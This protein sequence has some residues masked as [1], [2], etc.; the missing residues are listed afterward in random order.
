MNNSTRDIHCFSGRDLEDYS[1]VSSA[2]QDT[3]SSTLEEA[4]SL[5]STLQGHELRLMLKALRVSG[6][7]KAYGRNKRLIIA[8]KLVQ[9]RISMFEL[10]NAIDRTPIRDILAQSTTVKLEGSRESQ[11]VIWYKGDVPVFERDGSIRI[12]HYYEFV[13]FTNT[14]T[15]GREPNF[16]ASE[17][18][19]LGHVMIDPRMLAEL[20]R[21]SGR[22]TKDEL[23]RELEDPWTLSFAPLYNDPEF[24]PT[25]TSNLAGGITL[26]EIRH[27]D[28]ST[29][30]RSRSAAV[31]KKKWG[32]VRS[33]YTV[34]LERYE[35]SGQN[36]YSTFSDFAQGKSYVMYFHC[37]LELTPS[38]QPMMMRTVP[39]EARREIGVSDFEERR[40]VKRAGG[41]DLRDKKKK[42]S[43]EINISGL[44]L[45]SD[46][47]GPV[48]RDAALR[49]EKA[50]ATKKSS[51]EASSVMTAMSKVRQQKMEATTDDE[52]ED[53]STLL[54][55]L[56]KILN[57]L[58]SK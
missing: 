24:K 54:E 55:S 21:V 45:L 22:R 50:E 49:S 26:E 51:E 39:D 8:T 16:E 19:K 20:G 12:G 5:L 48:S 7:S 3:P 15:A 34:I 23:D 27:I 33:L 53:L 29:L 43:M 25:R 40:S 41:D 35:Q 58:I 37:I 38:L 10:R 11:R 42:K 56:K 32:E 31:L 1:E 57:E 46:A 4:Q 30:I 52:R 17:F 13:D 18:A 14:T 36:D 28:P 9:R 44:E 47:L 6:A 2:V